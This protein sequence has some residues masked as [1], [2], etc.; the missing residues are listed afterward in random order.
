MTNSHHLDI[1]RFFKDNIISLD[2]NLFDAALYKHVDYSNKDRGRCCEFLNY[3]LQRFDQAIAGG[4]KIPPCVESKIRQLEF[5]ARAFEN[6]CR[7]RDLSDFVLGSLVLELYDDDEKEETYD[8]SKHKATIYRFKY[9]GIEGGSWIL[10]DISDEMLLMRW[11]CFQVELL[12]ED[13]KDLDKYYND[14]FHYRTPDWTFITPRKFLEPSALDSHFDKLVENK[15]KLVDQALELDTKAY[16][17]L[18]F[19]TIFK[20]A[21]ASKELSLAFAVKF[22]YLVEDGYGRWAQEAIKEASECFDDLFSRLPV[23]YDETLKQ[24]LELKLLP[25]LRKIKS[26]DKTANEE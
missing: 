24:W 2:R 8:L 16:D 3:L 25:K 11:M 14:D 10:R 22:H 15:L 7:I 19:N 6:E 1:H 4:R 9:L 26:G 21:E 23:K 17:E 20:I 13:A 5:E 18:I 12:K